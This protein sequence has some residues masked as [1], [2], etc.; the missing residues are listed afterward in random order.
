MVELHH[1][2]RVEAG[3]A[4]GYYES[5]HDGLGDRF[6][7]ALEN[8]LE[9]IGKAPFEHPPWRY[10]GVPAGVRHSI[11]AVR[12]LVFDSEF[13]P[14]LTHIGVVHADRYRRRNAAW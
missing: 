9:A 11:M 5:V 13:T 12:E 8:C 7:T 10:R 14:A 4:A 1:L 2:A 6:A 3:E